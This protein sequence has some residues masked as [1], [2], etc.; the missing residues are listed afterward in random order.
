MCEILAHL[1]LF[2]RTGLDGVFATVIIVLP[3]AFTG[4]QI[5]VAY[6]SSS[7]VI[8]VASSS[9]FGTSV[10]AWYKDVKHEYLPVDSGYR[11]ALHYNLVHHAPPGVSL[12]KL[13]GMAK[14]THQ[15][16]NVLRNWKDGLYK[17]PIPSSIAYVLD[18][19]YS[20]QELGGGIN[21][22]KPPDLHKL[23]FLLPIAKELGYV[24]GLGSLL[25]IIKGY[26]TMRRSYYD[27]AESGEDDESEIEQMESPETLTSI[28]DI[29]NLDGVPIPGLTEFDIDT[30][31]FLSGTS[32]NKRKPDEKE[33]EEFPG[34]VR[35][36]FVPF[37]CSNV[38]DGFI[39]QTCESRQVDYREFVNQGEK[40]KRPC[41]FSKFYRIGFFRTAMILVHESKL[42]DA[43]FKKVQ[44]KKKGTDSEDDSF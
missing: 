8:D 37:M 30:E 13:P 9:L 32:I 31:G 22:L 17:A 7:E 28:S 4:G 5:H 34:Y 10:L 40:K 33:Y 3:S 42:G 11:L 18:H 15:L 29:V 24:I 39:L 38:A 12:P 23:T 44:K 1:V 14:A 43:S 26:A 35:H 41:G 19:R 6:A 20:V 25:H 36:F 16:Q 2:C 27:N 21:S